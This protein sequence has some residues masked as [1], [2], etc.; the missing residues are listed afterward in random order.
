M[1]RIQMP[2]LGPVPRSF[3]G[4]MSRS[5]CQG[6][7]PGLFFPATAAGIGRRQIGKAKTVCGR[8]VVRANCLSH[9]LKTEQDGIW[10]G[11]TA[12]ERR[13]MGG[14]TARQRLAAPA[15]TAP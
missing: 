15:G 9:A 2:L 11:T 14:R 7:D 12:Q 5:A 10:G 4:W 8:C 1:S 6:A 13:A 3:L